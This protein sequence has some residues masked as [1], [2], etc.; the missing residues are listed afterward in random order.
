MKISTRRTPADIA[1][2]LF[3]L[4]H[5]LPVLLHIVGVTLFALL[6]AWPRFVWGTLP[7]VVAA[8]AAMQLAIAVLNDYCDRHT[9]E[10]G[11][12]RKPI[13]LGLIRP[14]EA[15]LLGI[16]LIVVMAILLLPLPPLAWLI[17]L[18][19]LALGLAYNL[20]LKGTP[21]S[22]IVF[23]LAMPL[24]PVYAFVGVG[25]VLPLLF[26]LIPVGALLGV[27][28][29]LANS[30]PDIEDDAAQGVRTLAVVLGL[31]HSLFAC[32]LLILLSIVLVGLLALTH[33][34]PNSPLMLI[35]PLLLSEALVIV[36]S[37]FVSPV[38]ALQRRTRTLYFYL[39]ALSC[40][41]LVGGWIL[42]A[43]LYIT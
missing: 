42:G 17:S 4:I 30:L 41:L 36:A 11:K 5:P 22:G 19:Y 27:A 24:I 35:P 13:P 2:G 38:R 40:L 8:H 37:G 32:Q 33:T 12:K 6:A 16:A 31:R 23:A 39:I 18:L 21:L 20:G 34:V 10:L 26:W 1:R 25:H 14:T 43:I 3:L 7:L 28:L 9:D 29:N 15:L